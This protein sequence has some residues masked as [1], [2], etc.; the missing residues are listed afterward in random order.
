MVTSL[1]IA[2]TS[3]ADFS[4]K[5]GQVGNQVR[6][7]EEIRRFYHDY[8]PEMKEDVTF[9]DVL[10]VA[11]MTIKLVDVIKYQEIPYIAFR[12]FYTRRSLE[13]IQISERLE[14]VKKFV[15]RSLRGKLSELLPVV[16]E[17]PIWVNILGYMNPLDKNANV[18]WKF[19]ETTKEEKAIL[20]SVYRYLSNVYRKIKQVFLTPHPAYH[21]SIPHPHPYSKIERLL[22]DQLQKILAEISDG[23]ESMA[24][25]ELEDQ[26]GQEVRTEEGSQIIE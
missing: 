25:G 24:V 21:P 14:E 4:D 11:D 1:T 8:I 10:K 18:T 9:I 2:M 3:F 23:E 15:M 17:E 22:G 12:P 20:T 13:R 26:G 5:P 7:S 16:S 19:V 6:M